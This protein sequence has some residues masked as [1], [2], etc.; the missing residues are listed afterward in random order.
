MCQPGGRPAYVQR[1]KGRAA[2]RGVIEA[3]TGGRASQ[4]QPST[5][6][7]CSRGQRRRPQRCLKGA[8]A[9]A[10]AG[11]AQR[12]LLR[13]MQARTR[14]IPA[15]VAEAARP[16]AV[17]YPL[18]PGVLRQQ[19]VGSL[20]RPADYAGGVRHIRPV[21]IVHSGDHSLSS[22]RG[23]FK[24][25]AVMLPDGGGAAAAAAELQCWDT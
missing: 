13:V 15:N 16:A 23:Y 5:I 2:H 1:Q 17:L 3:Q 8:A 24:R 10:E 14:H 25:L 12:T 11:M 6:H 7:A 20:R 18:R 21:H 4:C 19:P 22:F 9:A